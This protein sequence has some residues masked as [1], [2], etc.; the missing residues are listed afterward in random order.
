VEPIERLTAQL[1]AGRGPTGS[2]DARGLGEVEQIR[3]ALGVVGQAIGLERSAIVGLALNL[4]RRAQ[5][6]GPA[7]AD[8]PS[9]ARGWR[10]CSRIGLM[11]RRW[12]SPPRQSRGRRRGRAGYSREMAGRS[13]LAEWGGERDDALRALLAARALADALTGEALGG[14]IAVVVGAQG[15]AELWEGP[16]E[17]A[18]KH[19]EAP[20]TIILGRGASDDAGDHVVTEPL[21]EEHRF[22][23]VVRMSEPPE[24]TGVARDPED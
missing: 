12:L 3:R 1:W 18:L 6:Q 22:A 9:G 2:D 16:A 4:A 10:S 24:L 13:A 23:V 8:P 15:D 11:W 17:A 19:S 7:F 14:S 5:L 21:A 20:L